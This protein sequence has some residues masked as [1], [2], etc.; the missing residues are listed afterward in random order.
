MSRQE[1]VQRIEH[2]RVS[3]I[4][5]THE[6]ALAEAAMRA[7]VAGGFRVVEFTL[8]TPGA[9]ELVAAFAANR[10]LLVGAGT[11]LTVEQVQAAKKAGAHFIVSP[12]WDP[13][14]IR[15]AGELDLASIPGTLTPTEMLAAHAAGADFVKLFPAPSDV[16][17]YVTALRGPLP[18]L[19]I[20]PTAGVTVENFLDILRAG[21]AGVG[22]VRSLFV[23]ADMAARDFTAIERRAAQIHARLRAGLGA[24][25]GPRP[26]GRGEVG[27]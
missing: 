13:A 14:V 6:A 7:A 26:P 9:L 20:F 10:D 24:E 5:R 12:V 25:F 4:V 18:Q 16:A 8:T 11:V 1:V 17:E 19:R 21:A 23:P 27:R 15:K 2:E 22:F 3:A